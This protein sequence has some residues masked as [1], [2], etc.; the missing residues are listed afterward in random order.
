MKTLFL[1]LLK[2]S[3]IVAFV[4]GQQPN[5]V[6]S[7]TEHIHQIFAADFNLNQCENLPA[8][9]MPDGTGVKLTSDGTWLCQK[10]SIDKGSGKILRL[11][12]PKE[13]QGK[14]LQVC[15]QTQLFVLIHPQ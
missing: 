7:H 2:L 8:T 12:V 10:F 3:A 5:N 15:N 13:L 4:N 1:N 6:E 9:Q 11:N 14:E